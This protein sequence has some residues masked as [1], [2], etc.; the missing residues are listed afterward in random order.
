MIPDE[1]CLGLVW[2]SNQEYDAEM[3]SYLLILDRLSSVGIPEL[4]HSEFPLP[5]LPELFEAIALEVGSNSIFGKRSIQKVIRKV[6]PEAGNELVA[7]IA[8]C[9]L[10]SIEHGLVDDYV[11]RRQNAVL[12]D[13]PMLKDILAETYG[14]ILYREQIEAIATDLAGFA[15][16]EAAELRRANAKLDWERI[17]HF[18]CQFI[19]GAEFKGHNR[20]D[21][22]KIWIVLFRA[23]RWVGP[24]KSAE[25][26]ASI[27]FQMAWLRANY[28]E[29][30]R[31]AVRESRIKD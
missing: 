6:S 22:E 25:R 7:S 15:P 18:H 13:D 9:R 1:R 28:P 26:I 31:K 19:D 11:S 20:G 27:V 23:A 21:A 4:A 5:Q 14:M 16:D 17:E 29:E 24:R 8:L 30:F 3:Q 12:S 2:E 10:Y